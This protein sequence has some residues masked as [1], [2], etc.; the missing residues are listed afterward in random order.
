MDENVRLREEVL[1]LERDYDRKYQS[2]ES[3]EREN[4]QQANDLEEVVRQNEQIIDELCRELKEVRG[5][6]ILSEQEVQ[7]LSIIRTT[8]TSRLKKQPN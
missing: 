5:T 2:L 8:N 3:A 6:A 4:R 1:K 7:K